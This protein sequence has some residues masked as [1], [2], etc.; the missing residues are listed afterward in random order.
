[1][2]MPGAWCLVLPSR[3]ACLLKERGS[4]L[5][6]QIP[7]LSVDEVWIACPTRL[8]RPSYIQHARAVTDS[9]KSGKQHGTA[10]DYRPV[11]RNVDNG[12][13]RF[14]GMAHAHKVDHSTSDLRWY[15]GSSPQPSWWARG[16]LLGQLGQ[17]L[18]AYLPPLGIPCHR[19][20][21]YFGLCSTGEGS[22]PRLS[23]AYK[24]HHIH[25]HIHPSIAHHRPPPPSPTD[26]NL[27]STPQLWLVSYYQDYDKQTN[28]CCL[29]ISLSVPTPHR[30][31]LARH[32]GR[33]TT[34]SS[35]QTFFFFAS[36][37]LRHGWLSASTVCANCSKWHDSARKL[38]AI[39][40][41]TPQSS[42]NPSLPR[43][44]SAATAMIVLMSGRTVTLHSRAEQAT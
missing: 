33:S 32:D 28:M 23:S 13:L 26:P 38:N 15:F 1:M 24:H 40:R 22:L 37:P 16:G 18:R 14:A 6:V 43:P 44:L 29:L 7:S 11:M 8:V 36:P 25:I 41:T 12:R 27:L 31:S 34:A 3:A 21:S 42:L 35:S 20:M 2:T 19:A 39:T 4:L 30:L 17:A 5:V 9:A 10:V